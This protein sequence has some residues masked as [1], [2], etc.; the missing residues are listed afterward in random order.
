MRGI[1]HCFSGSLETAEEMMKL[2]FYISFAGPLVSRRAA[3]SKKRPG[4]SPWT[5]SL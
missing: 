5:I 2:G 3:V 4:T 1:M